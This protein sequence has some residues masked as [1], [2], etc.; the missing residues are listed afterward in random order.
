MKNKLM[1]VQLV[2]LTVLLACATTSPMPG[3]FPIDSP[4]KSEYLDVMSYSF[5]DRSIFK[6]DLQPDHAILI[7]QHPLADIYHMKVILSDDLLSLRGMMEVRYFNR[8]ESDLSKIYFRLLPNLWG[9]WMQVSGVSVNGIAVNTQLINDNSA[10]QIPLNEIVAFGGYLDVQLNFNASLP[11]DGSGNY[12][13]FGFQDETLALAQFHPLLPI[14]DDGGW[15]I[16]VYPPNGDVTVSEVA[17]YLVEIDAPASMNLACSGVQISHEVEGDRQVVI[18]AAALSREF[19]LV[20]STKYQVKSTKVDGVSYTVHSQPEAAITVQKVLDYMS[21]AVAIFNEHIGAYPYRE[22]ELAATPTS[23]GGVEYPGVI[24]LNQNLFIPD[25]VMS[26]M[27]TQ[28][29]IE[30]VVV[31][32]VAHMWF[33]NMVGNDQG[34]EPWLDEAM[35]QYLTYVYFNDRYGSSAAESYAGSWWSRWNRVNQEP[36]P[37]GK[38]VEEYGSNEYGAIVYGRGPIFLQALSQEMGQAKFDLFLKDYFTQ[39]AWQVANGH[40]FMIL[41][42][43]T[44]DC[45]LA[46]L[47]YEWVFVE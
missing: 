5:N 32:E 38:P 24:A 46:P 35:A 40:D 10:L 45:N 44:C 15:H 33:Y 31:H 6:N 47:F 39:Y 19:Y 12:G 34:R 36:I 27:L 3:R 13:T 42:Q 2:L 1:I 20:A 21:T 11:Q 43:T 16:E 25:V 30:S 8:L 28:D 26:G 22:L 23:A 4:T 18:Q 29:L 17:N 37:I 14:H 41:A 9:D 7:D